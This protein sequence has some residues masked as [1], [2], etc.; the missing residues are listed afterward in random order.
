LLAEFARR[1]TRRHQA[2]GE[3]QP[4]R[5]RLVKLGQA[6]PGQMNLRQT[7]VAKRPEIAGAAQF[8]QK[9]RHVDEMWLCFGVTRFHSFLRNTI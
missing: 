8:A 9:R 1:K 4:E 2:V 5:L 6:Q 3:K 7:F